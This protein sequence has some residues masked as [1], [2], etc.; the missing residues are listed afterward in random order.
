[1]RGRLIYPFLLELQQL[2]T[3]ATADVPLGGY[4]PIF[5]EPLQVPDGTQFGASTRRETQLF[6]EAQ[7]DPTAFNAARVM[8]GGIVR[9]ARVTCM[10]HFR[11]L[12]DRGLLDER[13]QPMIRVNDRLAGIWNKYSRER[14]LDIPDPPGLYVRET[15][16][17][18][19]GFG[20]ARNLLQLEF[21]PRTQAR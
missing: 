11:E 12:E 19:F 2:D 16:V 21:A 18:G 17:T 3:R 5:N 8:A 13:G 9:D 20:G 7:V 6:V 10:V 1:M 14:V 15:L 4:D